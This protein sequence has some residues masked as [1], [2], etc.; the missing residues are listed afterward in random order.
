MPDTET[1]QEAYEL[2]QTQL[3]AT[4]HA[5]VELGA[6]QRHPSSGGVGIQGRD[7]L[8]GDE[9]QVDG[10][11]IEFQLAGQGARGIHQIGNQFNLDLGIAS[12]RGNPFAQRL[13]RTILT[14]DLHPT[15]N[16]IQRVAQLV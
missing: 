11:K 7:G 15:R 10:L 12:N 5:G 8:L 13:G 6:A 2:L 16:R 14:K 1:D 3:I 4:N 9:A